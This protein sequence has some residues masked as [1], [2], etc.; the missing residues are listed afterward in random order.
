[1]KHAA[2]RK[3]RAA[4]TVLAALVV[5]AAC[6]MPIAL[7]QCGTGDARCGIVACQAGSDTAACQDGMAGLSAAARA[8]SPELQQAVQDV[9]LPR[10]PQRNLP[11][12]AR[13]ATRRPVARPTNLPASAGHVEPQLPA[14]L[15]PRPLPTGLPAANVARELAPQVFAG[16]IAVTRE[17]D[18]Q[19]ALDELRRSDPRLADSAWLRERIEARAGEAWRQLQRVEQGAQAVRKMLQDEPRYGELR[20]SLGRTAQALKFVGSGAPLEGR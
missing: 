3:P 6:W 1:V 5:V 13:T 7:A 8:Q 16:A 20:D 14:S 15:D 12:I 18:H 19:R 11:E 9:I 17:L 2:L 4:R 10:V